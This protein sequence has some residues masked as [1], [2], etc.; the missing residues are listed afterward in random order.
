VVF[1]D[2][3]VLAWFPWPALKAFPFPVKVDGGMILAPALDLAKIHRL[4][5]SSPSFHTVTP[6]KASQ[7]LKIRRCINASGKRPPTADG[8]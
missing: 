8:H 2:G 6:S 4:R 1:R 7:T 5:A 3:L